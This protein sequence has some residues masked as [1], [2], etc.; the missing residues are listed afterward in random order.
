MSM[1]LP[2][3]T[4]QELL[5]TL[6]APKVKDY[7][8]KLE[9]IREVLLSIFGSKDKIVNIIQKYTTEP[10]TSKLHLQLLTHAYW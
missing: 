9:S 10:T 4:D 1:N 2:E 8:L 6:M 3:P 7:P 5:D